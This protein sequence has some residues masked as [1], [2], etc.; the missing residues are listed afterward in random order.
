MNA[1]R[2]EQGRYEGEGA[3]GQEPGLR[4]SRDGALQGWE[5]HI[6]AIAPQRNSICQGMGADT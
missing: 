1:S 3:G 4:K 2:Q 6:H 5:N